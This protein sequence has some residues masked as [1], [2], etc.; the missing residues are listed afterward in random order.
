MLQRWINHSY[1][2]FNFK[3]MVNIGIVHFW[4][5]NLNRSRAQDVVALDNVRSGKFNFAR[6][7][8]V[9]HITTRYVLLSLESCPKPF[10]SAAEG[11]LC[12]DRNGYARAID[13]VRYSIQPV[14]WPIRTSLPESEQI[15]LC[16]DNKHGKES[17]GS[18]RS[19]AAKS[20]GF[21]G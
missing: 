9:A 2:A 19:R 3:Q 16:R 7:T 14:G 18:A 11:R 21:A 5:S 20:D 6:M 12:S 1:F 8:Y 4:I 15:N 13:R 17:F 10:S